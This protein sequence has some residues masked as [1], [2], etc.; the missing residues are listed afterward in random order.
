MNCKHA[1]EHFS[2]FVAGELDRAMSVSLENHLH[3]CQ[4]C[5]DS[6]AEL[7]SVWQTLDKMDVVE[8][9]ADFHAILMQ[10]LNQ[11]HEQQ[12]APVLKMRPKFDWRALFQV[13]SFAYAAAALVVLL[14]GVEVYQVN[15]A[16]SG[17]IGSILQ[18]I[19]P[20]APMKTNEA[21]WEPAEQGGEL[22]IRLQPN[23]GFLGRE[24]HYRYSLDLKRK[25]GKI[26]PDNL[27][28]HVEGDMTSANETMVRMQLN[29]LPSITEYQLQLTLTPISGGN[30]QQIEIPLGN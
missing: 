13:R 22:V 19:A 6:V 5:R 30:N 16:S 15:Q 23:K 7:R 14:L 2:D 4:E 10:R 1:Q 9:P 25:D 3:A 26:D 20:N 11:E 12:S 27:A 29:K 17:P 8:P 21:K 24:H 18:I 28:T